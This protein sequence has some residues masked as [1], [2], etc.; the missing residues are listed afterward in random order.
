MCA[1]VFLRVGVAVLK[2]A[3]PKHL[4]PL[5]PHGEYRVAHESAHVIEAC[6][7]FIGAIFKFQTLSGIVTCA[8]DHTHTIYN[9]FKTD[10]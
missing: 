4:Q 2:I 5:H 3:S 8:L 1:C 7:A 9:P 10:F 6:S